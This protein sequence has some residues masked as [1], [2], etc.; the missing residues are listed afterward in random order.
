M[1]VIHSPSPDVPESEGG[2]GGSVAVVVWV[3]AVVSVPPGAAVV[4]AGAVDVVWSV[5]CA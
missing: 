5:A 4:D 3:P 1:T 2:M